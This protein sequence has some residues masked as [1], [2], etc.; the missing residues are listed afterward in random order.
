VYF[1]YFA[2]TCI[3]P[4]KF[5]SLS[6]L[7]SPSPKD[8]L[9]QVWIEL[10]QWLW[11]RKFLNEP[12]PFLHFFYYLPFEK[13]QALFEQTSIPFTQGYFVPSLIEIGLLVQEI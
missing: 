9:C 2:I 10:A 13:G 3:S 6:K 7:E 5:P 1:Y 12:T 4:W 8:D 11:R